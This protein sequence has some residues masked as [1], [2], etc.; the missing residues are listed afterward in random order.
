MLVCIVATER[1]STLRVGGQALGL[2]QRLPIKP[3]PPVGRPHR[4]EDFHPQLMVQVSDGSH[5]G[6]QGMGFRATGS[7]EMGVWVG[8]WGWSHRTEASSDHT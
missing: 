7:W 5:L 4:D 8:A 2:E 6:T 1:S 3:A